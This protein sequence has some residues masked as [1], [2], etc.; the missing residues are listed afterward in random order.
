M[1]DITLLTDRRYVNPPDPD[2]YVKNILEED[3]LV[4]E[5]LEQRGL[6][7]ART[8]WD[9]PHY[10]WKSTRF[11]L[12]RT[13]WDY[14]HR[15]NEFTQWLKQVHRQTHLINPFELIAWNM[16]KH[17]LRD[18]HNRGIAIPPTVFIEAGLQQPLTTWVQQTG[19]Q[20]CIL[21]PAV[22]GTA[23][24]TYRF[25]SVEASA[26]QP[27][28]IKLIHRESMLLQEFQQAVLQR[29]EVALMVFNGRFSH[30]VLKRARPGDFRVQDDF[31]GTVHPYTPTA[32]EVAFA[33]Q[34]V[35]VCQP[36]PVYARVDVIWNNHGQ[37]CVSEL[38]LI[39]PELWF[40]FHPPAAQQF[41]E[42]IVKYIEA[43]EAGNLKK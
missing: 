26:Y 19:W 31:G 39:E 34:V 13:T 11:A 24:H 3:R 10:N 18:L 25:R 32:D 43:A 27:V 20:E 9:N 16:D 14:F 7:V 5:A 36:L 17:Y 21:K 28:Y 42:S 35:G 15:Y 38:E 33:E 40:R 6:Q 4:R 37:P 1:T 23:R 12:F 22:S 2:W 29:G 41:A 8:H 30:A